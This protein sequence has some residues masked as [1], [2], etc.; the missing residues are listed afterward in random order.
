MKFVRYLFGFRSSEFSSGEKRLIHEVTG[1]PSE[2]LTPTPEK[3]PKTP[4]RVRTMEDAKKT[5]ARVAGSP[6]YPVLSPDGKTAYPR[7]LRNY[8][9]LRRPLYARRFSY[10][11]APRYAVWR[12]RSFVRRSGLH[13]RNAF[14]YAPYR[15]YSPWGYRWGYS[16]LPR[17]F[18]TPQEWHDRMMK[19]RNE[20]ERVIPRSMSYGKVD[21][22]S[23][24]IPPKRDIIA[25]YHRLGA[26]NFSRQ[27][28]LTN[29]A[30][31]KYDLPARKSY[32]SRMDEVAAKQREERNK[33][34]YEVATP[35]NEPVAR[36]RDGVKDIRNRAWDASDAKKAVP[37]AWVSV[38]P[39]RSAAEAGAPS[40]MKTDVKPSVSVPS[41]SLPPRAETPASKVP[42]T[43]DT[44]RIPRATR[45]LS[46]PEFVAPIEEE[47]ETV[48]V[49][50]VEKPEAKSEPLPPPVAPIPE[51]KAAPA[52]EPP[53]PAKIPEVTV[54]EPKKP[55]NADDAL[56]ELKAPQLDKKTEPPTPEPSKKEDFD[57]ML[58][59]LDAP[60][61]P[62]NP[63]PTPSTDTSPG[64]FG[65]KLD[66]L[67]NL[68]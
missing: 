65:G 12:T 19:R 34:S 57:K 28:N 63:S 58:N 51:E 8:P 52:V 40:A 20:A 45:P 61:A 1:T 3:D 11:Y 49:P 41:S 35:S 68:K 17:R 67:E 24:W 56:D 13:Y 15:M 44:T 25:E 26:A 38:P 53:A 5:A 14:A 36:I 30:R 37:S 7:A 18:G 31:A 62:A 22:A 27:Q 32:E 42:V 16:G 59:E 10:V 54:P 55:I 4:E 39:T 21:R 66:E 46:S 50:P 64:N 29:A 33:R 47:P 43:P 23:R 60:P 9:Y 2:G 48:P 6:S